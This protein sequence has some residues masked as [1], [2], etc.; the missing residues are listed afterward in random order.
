MN[1]RKNSGSSDVARA[2]PP[3]TALHKNK[4]NR[5]KFRWLIVNSQLLILN[6]LTKDTEH[7]FRI[8][9]LEF[10]IFPF[11]IFVQSRRSRQGA[12]GIKIN[13]ANFS[14]SFFPLIAG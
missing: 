1:R 9:N 8:Y 10:T 13:A 11:F 2:K 5:E 3:F 14:A 7:Q 4:G 12:G 6:C